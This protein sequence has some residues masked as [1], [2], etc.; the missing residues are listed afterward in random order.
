MS[1]PY[2]IHQ[3][4]E[5]L[6]KEKCLPSGDT[7]E[8]EKLG[9]EKNSRRFNT[10]PELVDGPSFIPMRY[11]GKAPLLNEPSSYDATF[12]IAGHRVRGVGFEAIGRSN[13]RFKKR[14][15]QGWHLNVCDPNLPTNDPKQNIHQPLPDFTTTDFRDFINQTAQLWKIDLGWEWDTELF[16]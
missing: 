10:S 3:I 14:I 6:E 12:L 16:S 1:Y 11:L 15:P 5:F 13:F 9:R 8:L 2:K 7:L 4:N